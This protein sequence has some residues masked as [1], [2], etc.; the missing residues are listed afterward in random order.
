MKAE[1]VEA[2]VPQL[3]SVQVWINFRADLKMFYIVDEERFISYKTVRW[4]N[5]GKGGHQEFWQEAV[6]DVVETSGDWFVCE[7]K[8]KIKS[9]WKD[10][11]T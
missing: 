1:N 5:W 2:T 4:W 6:R 9:S 3:S 7:S 8:V 11:C 10:A